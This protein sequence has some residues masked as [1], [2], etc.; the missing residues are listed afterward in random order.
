MGQEA[1]GETWE[2]ITKLDFDDLTLPPFNV[3]LDMDVE[4]TS[5]VSLQFGLKSWSFPCNSKP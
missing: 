3:S 1:V 4:E 5:E 2:N